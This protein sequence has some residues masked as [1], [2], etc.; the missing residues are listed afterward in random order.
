MRIESNGTIGLEAKENRNYK[1]SIFE[2]L[3]YEDN[4]VSTNNIQ[5]QDL[6]SSDDFLKNATGEVRYRLTN[7]Y[8]FRAVLQKNEKVLRG[9]VCSLLHLEKE[10]I[11]KITITNPIVLGD[12][13]NEKT[14]IMD[15]ALLLNDD[16]R[17][18]LEMQVVNYNDWPERSLYSLSRDF[19]NL[20]RGGNY[21][22]VLPLLHINILDFN[23]FPNHPAFYSRNKV[24]DQETHHVYSS[25]FGINVLELNQIELATDEDKVWK[26]DYW[27]KLFKA[28]TWEEIQM[29]A[30]QDKTLHE[31]ASAL[32]AMSE[33]ERIRMQCIARERYEMDQK[34]LLNQGRKEQKEID[35][36]IIA[37]KDT[38]LSIKD[39]ALAE[40]DA[41]IAALK[42]QLNQKNH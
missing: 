36:A 15:V 8:M 22:D 9:F 5:Q 42:A 30:E 39:T 16:Q 34:S 21:Y 18:N 35:D 23:L 28:N 6:S 37:E 25:K 13:I 1:S 29:K 2:D 27:A 3:F 26:L 24:M 32:R 19:C 33:D 4:Q 17:L 10:T 20:N 31:C 7:D 40:K 14:I 11:K 12:A 41:E 38:A